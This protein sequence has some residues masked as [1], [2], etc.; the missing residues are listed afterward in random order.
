M[1]ND[2]TYP[3]PPLFRRCAYKEVPLRW[4]ERLLHPFTKTKMVRDFAAE[5]AAM[6]LE[7]AK[8]KA[9]CK[10]IDEKRRGYQFRPDSLME[11]RPAPRIMPLRRSQ[12]DRY[13]PVSP[14]PAPSPTPKAYRYQEQARMSDSTSYE[15]PT[16][17]W[18][19]EPSALQEPANEEFKSG[20]EGQFAG[21]GASD[22]WEPPP[23]SPSPSPAPAPSDSG[24][25]DS[26]SSSSD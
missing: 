14:R 12:I 19:Y 7:I 1:F 2:S 16:I 24:S 9:L 5:E 21:G 23:P 25:S 4:W 3:A 26:S 18:R 20:G 11:G 13:A 10:S 15:S 22:S 8:Y 17:P 6:D